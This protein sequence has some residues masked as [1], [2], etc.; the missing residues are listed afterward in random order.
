PH[1][2]WPVNVVTGIEIEYKAVWPLD[3]FKDRVPCVDLQYAHLRKA[4]DPADVLGDQVLAQLCFLLDPHPAQRLR[5]P[6]LRVL[7]EKTFTADPFWTSDKR[8]RTAGRMRNDPLRNCFVVARYIELRE[9]QV[10]IENSIRVRNF[11]AR[12]GV[13][14]GRYAR[15]ALSGCFV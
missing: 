15:T 5:R 8:Q 4:G 1:D 14:E 3:V 6:D 2:C 7:H 9:L 13:G 10:R 12:D 11:D